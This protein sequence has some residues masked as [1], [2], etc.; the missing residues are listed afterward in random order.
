MDAPNTGATTG[1]YAA[2]ADVSESNFIQSVE[3]PANIAVCGG[4]GIGHRPGVVHRAHRHLGA[5]QPRVGHVEPTV[6]ELRQ[7]Y[8]SEASQGT[9]I[10]TWTDVRG[11]GDVHHR[12]PDPHRAGRP[13]AITNYA[14]LSLR[15]VADEA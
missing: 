1:L 6:T 15:F 7:G 12:H 8:A 2:L 3:S 14:A 9:L 13:N 4:L 11:A 5:P 10:A